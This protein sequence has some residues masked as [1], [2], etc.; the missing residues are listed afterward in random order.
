MAQLTTID[1]ESKIIIDDQLDS[2][3][4]DRL[5]V[6]MCCGMKRK[7]F[8]RWVAVVIIVL[9]VA[10]LPIC[11]WILYSRVHEEKHIVAWFVA[12]VFALLTIPISCFGMILHLNHYTKPHIQRYILRIQ[13]MPPVY[14]LTSWL[15]LLRKEHAIYLETIRE[16]YEAYVIYSFAFYLIAV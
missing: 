12:G 7:I 9:I 5:T 13:L 10:A 4:M 6:P 15:A 11:A 14:G 3:M 8:L 16:C 2:E 1:D